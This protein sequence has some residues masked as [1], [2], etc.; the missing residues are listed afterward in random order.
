MW[1]GSFTVSASSAGYL[2]YIHSVLPCQR[3]A[4]VGIVDKRHVHPHQRGSIC[5]QH[6]TPDQR[7]QTG[8]RER[9][10]SEP[11]SSV[12]P[13]LWT[14]NHLDWLISLSFNHLVC[15][16]IQCSGR[17]KLI[18]CNNQQPP[19]STLAH[20]NHV[21]GWAYT[22]HRMMF[23]NTPAASSLYHHPDVCYISWDSSWAASA[24][25]K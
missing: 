1:W 16:F 11:S 17:P 18:N 3:V 22:V 23:Y 4:V 24:T 12:S 9:R 15:S 10:Q 21:L 20:V 7:C 19:R 25:L 2:L 13:T 5:S 14:I 6:L 8:R